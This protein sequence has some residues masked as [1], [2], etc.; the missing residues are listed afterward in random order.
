MAAST[1]SRSE[2]H[3]SELQSPMYHVCRLL[4]E[5]K[6]RAAVA[7][8]CVRAHSPSPPHRPDSWAPGR[9]GASACERVSQSATPI[10]RAEVA[11]FFF[12]IKG[13]PPKSTPFPYTKPFG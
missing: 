7:E 4:L 5:K 6:T 2:E 3:T 11:E 12:L 10:S 8:D 9:L 1:R 13:P